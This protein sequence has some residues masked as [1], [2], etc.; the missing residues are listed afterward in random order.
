MANALI[1]FVILPTEGQTMNKIMSLLTFGETVVLHGG[2]VCNCPE[3]GYSAQFLLMGHNKPFLV[4]Q[5][6]I[7]YICKHRLI[8]TFLLTNKMKCSLL[9]INDN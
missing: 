6:V 1:L 9:I 7:C 4:A 2:S 3:T 5:S 8:R